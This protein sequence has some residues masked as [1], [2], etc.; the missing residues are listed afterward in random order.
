V[1]FNKVYVRSSFKVL[2]AILAF[3]ALVT[4]GSSVFCLWAANDPPSNQ[5]GSNCKEGKAGTYSLTGPSGANQAV[6]IASKSDLYWDRSISVRMDDRLSQVLT[7]S[8]EFGDLAFTYQGLVTGQLPRL[9]TQTA[10]PQKLD[11]HVSL[12]NLKVVDPKCQEQDEDR[13]SRVRKEVSEL[14]AWLLAVPEDVAIKYTDFLKLPKTGVAKILPRGLREDVMLTRG[15]GAYYSFSRR[16]HEYGYGS[17]IALEKGLFRVGFAGVDYGF[18]VTLGT[19]AIESIQPTSDPPT[20]LALSE[21]QS[22]ADA[23]SYRPPKEIGQLRKEV[24]PDQ[25]HVLAREG[26]TYLLRSIRPRQSDTLTAF[27]VERI[28]GDGSAVIVWRLL[29]SWDSVS[30]ESLP[31]TALPQGTLNNSA[32]AFAQ[33]GAD[34]AS[35]SGGDLTDVAVLFKVDPEYTKEARQ[36][37]LAG[38]VLLSLIVDTEGKARDIRVVRS[39]GMGLD[40]KAIEALQKWKFRPR[41]KNGIA[42]TIRA[43]VE[44]NFKP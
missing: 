38:A 36:A 14:E 15:G 19:R 18:F 40:E 33:G 1:L 28:L 41:T 9:V 32:S 23:W 7:L 2:Y 29:S 4:C 12:F 5:S 6:V 35:K 34:G 25:N 10:P 24:R 37:K 27:R 11:A 3:V 22:W 13:I 39:L 31:D 21:R 17:D 43:N 30:L 44:M 8:A 42:V 16:A 20:W 26:L